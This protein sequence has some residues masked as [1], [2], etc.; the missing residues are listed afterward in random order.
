M[1]AGVMALFVGIEEKH[2]AH[3]SWQYYTRKGT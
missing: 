1:T 2:P 3:E